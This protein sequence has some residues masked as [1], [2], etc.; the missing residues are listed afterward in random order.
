MVEWLYGEELVPAE[1]RMQ[2]KTRIL[3]DESR[4]DDPFP[5]QSK[6]SGDFSSG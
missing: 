5:A 3:F 4:I 2:K 6:V 1:S